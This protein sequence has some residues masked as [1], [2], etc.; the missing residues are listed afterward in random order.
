MA[1]V[2]SNTDAHKPS[3]SSSSSSAPHRNDRATLFTIPAPLKHIFTKFPLVT[4]APNTLPLCAPPSP[5]RRSKNNT[6]YIFT[7]PTDAAE[8]RP[9][10]NPGCLKWQTLLRFHGIPH[11]T[12]PS[13]NHASPSGALPFLLPRAS[14]S[15]TDP[16]KPP[17]AVAGPKLTSWL[18][19]QTPA[20][21]ATTTTKHQ[22]PPPPN[23]RLAAYTTLLTPIRLA[24]LHALYLHP[25]TFRSLATPLYITPCSSNAL[26]Q[27]S[28]GTP[29]RAAAL[30]QLLTGAGGAGA[31]L[32]TVDIEA[33][34][35]RA[36]EAVEALAVLLGEL[37]WFAECAGWTNE[38]DDMQGGEAT[39]PEI[40]DASI[41][42]YTHTI[43]SLF[44]NEAPDT[45][46]ARLFRAL[47]AQG[48]LVAHRQRVLDEFY[49]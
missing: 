43:L 29:L 25:T 46:A 18:K 7:T 49:K 45:P 48:N 5:E 35:I 31:P 38:N 34:Y 23:T 42:A 8:N 11:V 39:R 33:L 24:Y 15:D 22:L 4:Y 37:R 44:A 14:S 27:A 17:P 12:A 9:S 26:V 32:S 19:A 40:T 2:S 3:S 21:T 16:S 47:D 30:D 28:L 6:L 41:F 13:S 1:P 10:Y 20:P 36:E